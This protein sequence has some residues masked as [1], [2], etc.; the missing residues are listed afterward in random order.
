MTDEK[1]PDYA[2]RSAVE[3]RAR[4][5]VEARRAAFE[6]LLVELSLGLVPLD[7]DGDD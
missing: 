7:K 3:Q 5:D 6:A 1:K 4:E 2:D